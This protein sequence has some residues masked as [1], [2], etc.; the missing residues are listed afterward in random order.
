MRTDERLASAEYGS[1]G[2]LLRSWRLSLG[3]ANKSP[4]TIDSYL[5]SAVLFEAFVAEHFGIT[6]VATLAREHVESFISD[7]L[8]HW[9][10]KTASIRYGN[11]QQLFKWLLEEGEIP[12]NPMARMKPPKVPEVPVPVI[13]DEDL[14]KL[15]KACSGSG[16]EERRD[17]A[18]LRVFIDGGVRLAEITNLRL[19]DVDLELQVLR[20]IGKGSRP[21]SVPF[22][23]KTA[24]AIDLYLRARA[25]TKSPALAQ[26]W[27]AKPSSHTSPLADPLTGLD[28]RVTR[29]TLRRG[30]FL[31]RSDS[32]GARVGAKPAPQRTRMMAA[33]LG[34]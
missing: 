12:A 8:Q 16:F 22:G 1:L 14:K 11:L 23:P 30:R 32:A 33:E 28:S 27:R 18:I 17:T 15:L 26:L 24:M 7:Q 9:K 4:R 2:A 13:P 10:P 21:R 31:V 3:A 34:D 5:E 6:D 19:E 20:V 25:K 29:G